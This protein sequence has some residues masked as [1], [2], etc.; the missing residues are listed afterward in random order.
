MV[1]Y[2][3][4]AFAGFTASASWGDKY[5]WDAALSYTNDFGDFHV[6][7]K[8][9]YGSS[10]DPGTTLED[11]TAS[12]TATTYVTGGSPC[13]SWLL[14]LYGGWGGQSVDTSHVFPAGTAFVQDSSFWNVQPGIEHKWL[15]LGT[16]TIFGEYRRDDP[17]SNPDKTVDASINF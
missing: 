11:I 1:R 13:I 5:L 14:R 2:D 6:V 3:S 12:G 8:A 17:G 16:T 4:L 9:G 7:A 15:P 10:N